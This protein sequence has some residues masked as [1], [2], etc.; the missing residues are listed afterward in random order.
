VVDWVHGRLQEA[1]LD[2]A[3]VDLAPYHS[4]ANYTDPQ[5]PL[6]QI[7][8]RNA[9]HFYGVDPTFTISTG[10]TDGRFFRKRGVPTIIYG[11]RPRNC[12]A[13]DEHV[14]LE[15]F[16]TVLRVHVCSAIDYIAGMS[17]A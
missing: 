4:A 1:G 13:L 10:A 16:L 3:R 17:R 5:H 15:D 11:P 7:V 2:S 12:A 8:K 14:T 9:A 6:S